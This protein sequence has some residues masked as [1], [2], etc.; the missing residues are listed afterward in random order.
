MSRVSTQNKYDR[1]ISHG[2]QTERAKCLFNEFKCVRNYYYML[3]MMATATAAA[4]TTNKPT[5]E[6]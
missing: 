3:M 5:D 6:L 1:T 2:T 4:V